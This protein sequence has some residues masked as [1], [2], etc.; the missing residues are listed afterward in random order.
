MNRNQ[1]FIGQWIE[2]DG[3]NFLTCAANAFFNKLRR[4]TY[5]P[6]IAPAEAEDV[7]K[8]PERAPALSG[9]R[10]RGMGGDPRADALPVA[11]APW[12][13]PWTGQREGAEPGLTKENLTAPGRAET[14]HRQTARRER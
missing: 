2:H 11:R 4:A 8:A 1:R 9:R 10:R 14:G 6:R 13:F 3:P 12:H 5:R 7:R